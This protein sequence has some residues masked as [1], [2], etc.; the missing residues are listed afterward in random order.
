MFGCE[1]EVDL[2]VLVGE[3]HLSIGVQILLFQPVPEFKHLE[4]FVLKT[5]A[6]A[7]TSIFFL[8]LWALLFSWT[9]FSWPSIEFAN[10]RTLFLYHYLF[11]IEVCLKV[12]SMPPSCIG[13]SWGWSDFRQR[14]FQIVW[15]RKLWECSKVISQLWGPYKR[16]LRSMW[17]EWTLWASNVCHFEVRNCLL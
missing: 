3:V 17:G 12:C 1:L 6:L 4:D 8:Q 10:S 13:V 2:F 16:F 5:V 7:V 15:G 9:H 14:Y 11:W